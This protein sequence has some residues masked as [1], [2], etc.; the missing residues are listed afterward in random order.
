MIDAY[1]DPGEN[2]PLSMETR[3]GRMQRIAV[4]DV[5]QKVQLWSEKYGPEWRKV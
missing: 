3:R 2:Y 1:G 4:R 5:V